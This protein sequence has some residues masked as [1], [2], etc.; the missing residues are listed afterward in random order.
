MV[1]PVPPLQTAPVCVPGDLLADVELVIFD[2]DGVVVDS[3][4]ISL[5][6]LRR[7]LA[8]FGIELSAEEVR[9]R[10]L[11]TS[12]K[13]IATYVA[14]HSPARSADGFATHWEAAL[15]ESFRTD[16]T[17]IP[18]LCELLSALS[19]QGYA[20]CIAS[21]GTF[22]RIDVAL[23]STGLV[24]R[25]DH[26]FSA[27]QVT[28]GKPAPD[29]FLHAAKTI[30]VAP[31]HCLVI[32]DSPYGARAATE[33]GMRCIGFVGGAHVVDIASA[34]GAILRHEGAEV[35]LTSY[36]ALTEQLIQESKDGSGQ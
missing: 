31:Q 26:I 34:H 11:G 28:R 24:A 2:C 25:F 33:A 29:L 36:A 20:H 3:E 35:V 22:E 30:G 6:S 8:A 12:L 21:S 1:S 19:A 5:A 27:E 14:E 10:F 7:S 23:S 4:V 16:L 18:G 32:E 9:S 13:S 15:F 17:P